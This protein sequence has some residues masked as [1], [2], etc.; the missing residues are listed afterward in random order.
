MNLLLFIIEGACVRIL[1]RAL[2]DTLFIDSA[3]EEL[4][5]LLRNLPP[6]IIEGAVFHFTPY[7]F[8]SPQH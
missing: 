7:E 1:V 5:S 8:T 2:V 4:T 3:L 6:A